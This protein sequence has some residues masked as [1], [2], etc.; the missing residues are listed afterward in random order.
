M[1]K[2]ILFI[3]ENHTVPYD[4][5]VWSEAIAAR[6]WGYDVSVVSPK[7]PQYDKSFEVIEGIDVY[8]YPQFFEA[9][10]KFGYFFEYINALFFQFLL[11]AKIMARK[12]FHIIHGANPP[13]NIF[14]IALIFRPFKVKYV[15]DHH[16]LCT[17][18]Y[19]V[20]FGK[21]DSIYKLLSLTELLSLKFADTVISTNESYKQIAAAALRRNGSR[22]KIHVVRN[23]PDTNK[24]EIE[25][26]E[27]N[28]REGF[29]YLIG[30]VGVIAQQEGIDILLRI[31]SHIVRDRNIRDI[32]F[33]VIGSGPNLDEF[34]ELSR[35]MG[36]EE[37]VEF[38]GFI[39]YKNLLG[40]L[41]QCDIGIN[42][43]H[44]NAYTDKSTM[45]KIMDY[46][47]VGKPIIQFESTEGYNT[48]KDASLYIRDNNEFEFA[49]QILALLQD[50]DRRDAMG[51]IGRQRI[52]E[53]LNWDIQKK[54][55][56]KAY[57]CVEER[58]GP[59]KKSG[60]P[61]FRIG[62][63]YTEIPTRTK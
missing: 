30:Y 47:Y 4:R 5:R 10:Q 18:L 51:R 7:M 49:E 38:T 50:K 17:E 60:A 63:R 36:L 27:R 21:T 6:Q 43:E 35:T 11:S 22:K 20:K 39:P 29:S 8:R 37:Y 15:F 53:R 16:D 55:L 57:E 25:K 2:H 12:K 44:T 59:Q 3:V 61:F 42:P 34:A 41:G 52:F 45:M 13:D 14:L 56:K 58:N 32:K 1:N 62:T 54:N 46:M 48:A 31:V 33:I 28:Y 23:G 40:I 9:R 19:K 26:P 24:I